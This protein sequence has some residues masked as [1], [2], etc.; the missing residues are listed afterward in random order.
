MI[1]VP[2][3]YLIG[4]C[5]VV[6]VLEHGRF[7]SIAKEAEITIWGRA[8]LSCFHLDIENL[9]NTNALS[10]PLET[11]S[12]PELTIDY[13]LIKNDGIIMPWIGY[14]D[15]R[16][17]LV[18]YKNAEIVVK[19][20]V[21]DFIRSYPNSILQF[22]EPLPQFVDMYMKYEGFNETY[23]YEARQAENQDFIN[24]LRSYCKELNLPEP[25]SQDK[26]YTAVGVDIFTD[27]VVQKEN[28]PHPVDALLNTYYGELYELFIKTG[29]TSY[30]QYK[31]GV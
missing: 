12:A 31:G 13:N 10:S 8:G 11:G 9:Q 24:A 23:S 14:V 4:D 20:Y 16:Q 7:K 2:K 26:I 5:H 25:L 21:D 17:F 15:I 18:K 28:R 27:A 3:I 30:K 1:N 29:I 19:K 22:I 6:R